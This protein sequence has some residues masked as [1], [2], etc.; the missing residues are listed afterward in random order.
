MI[1]LK[2]H[3]QWMEPSQELYSRLE[4]RFAPGASQLGKV[5]GQWNSDGDVDEK[6]QNGDGE[7]CSDKGRK[8]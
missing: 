6:G 4:D 5:D 2:N 1:T 8:P 7:G 3:R